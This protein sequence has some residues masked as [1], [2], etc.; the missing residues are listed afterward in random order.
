MD[1]SV[2]GISIDGGTL[3]ST[4]EPEE[5]LAALEQL[6]GARPEPEQPD[7]AYDI[8]FYDW[9]PVSASVVS[10][11][12]ISLT[13]ADTATGLT[14]VLANGI[15]LGS[16]REEAMAAGAEAGWDEDGDGIADYLSIEHREVPG[17]VSLA[18]PGEEGVEYIQLKITDDVVGEL[19][20]GAN[21]FSDL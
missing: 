18:R 21:D 6:L 10:G 15:G 17:T 8:V 1:V 2:D 13:F 16:T 20:N 11:T 19:S 4:R 14:V 7:P 5:T 3:L 12:S 9:G